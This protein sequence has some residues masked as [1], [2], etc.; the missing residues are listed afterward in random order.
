MRHSFKSS[1]LYGIFFALCLIG[2]ARAADDDIDWRKTQDLFNRSNKG[3]KLTPEDQTYLDHAKEVRKK[4][5]AEGKAPWRDQANAQNP[6]QAGGT[7]IGKTPTGLVS[8]TEL[9]A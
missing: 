5:T 4:L 6:K 8:L 1:S 9:G 2:I 7:L 3:E